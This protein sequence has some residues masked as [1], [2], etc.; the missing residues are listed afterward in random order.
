VRGEAPRLRIAYLILFGSGTRLLLFFYL[1]PSLALSFFIVICGLWFSVYF[2]LVPRGE[3]FATLSFG[4][5]SYASLR[6]VYL[7]GVMLVCSSLR[8]ILSQLTR[9]TLISVFVLWSSVL[10][11][12][13]IINSD[14]KRFRFTFH[15]CSL[16]LKQASRAAD[17]QTTKRIAPAHM[18]KR[19]S[20]M[21]SKLSL[22]LLVLKR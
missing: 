18:S 6:I 10:D 20:G 4:F 22:H 5:L 17:G 3:Q 12:P 8:I 14:R 21:V 11:I 16:P 15:P 9:D 19:P 2:A 13:T 1:R 7:F